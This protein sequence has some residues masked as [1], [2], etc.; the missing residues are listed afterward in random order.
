MTEQTIREHVEN[1][2]GLTWAE[3]QKM[4]HADRVEKMTGERPA[5]LDKP[6]G[7]ERLAAFHAALNRG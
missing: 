5:W 7:P 1:D 3:W 2:L 4:S 6:A